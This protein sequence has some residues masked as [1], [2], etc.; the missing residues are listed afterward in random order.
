MKNKRNG[1]SMLY[2]PAKSPIIPQHLLACWCLVGGG[3]LFKCDRWRLVWGRCCCCSFL[4][5]PGRPLRARDE[6]QPQCCSPEK[7][8]VVP[9]SVFWIRANTPPLFN[10]L[11]IFRFCDVSSVVLSS[12]KTIIS[13]NN[14]QETDFS[15][16]SYV[17]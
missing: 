8:F 11:F 3:Q 14:W 15:G 5:R 17:L 4:L 2:L 16:V 12:N 10:Y 6:P 13:T 7:P 9:Q 1:Y